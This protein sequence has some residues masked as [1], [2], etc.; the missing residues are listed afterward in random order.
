MR[1]ENNN[2]LI[3]FGMTFIYF[4]RAHVDRNLDFF[5]PPP[6]LWTIL[7]IRVYVVIWTWFV[8]AP[9]LQFSSYERIFWSKFA[10]I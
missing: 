6:P 10:Q 5:D 3:P 2:S 9:L 8:N 7:L 4:L 1:N